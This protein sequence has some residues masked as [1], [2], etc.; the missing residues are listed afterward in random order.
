MI[1]PQNMIHEKCTGEACRKGGESETGRKKY[2]FNFPDRAFF[3]LCCLQH[4]QIQ[5][6]K[7]RKI[8]T[9]ND[10]KSISAG[11]LVSARGHAFFPA[12]VAE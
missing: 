1:L 11:L 7:K 3:I 9:R 4:H 2:I 10:P 5:R 6:T 12:G 8:N